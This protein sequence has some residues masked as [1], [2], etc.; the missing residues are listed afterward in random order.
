MQ[1]PLVVCITVL[2]GIVE[3]IA[4][5]EAAVGESL[6]RYMSLKHIQ[7]VSRHTMPARY[8]DLRQRAPVPQD[9]PGSESDSEDKVEDDVETSS[10]DSN[11]PFDEKQFNTSA[12]IECPSALESMQSVVNPSGLAACYNVPF[13]DSS[14]GTFVVDL[15][16]F[17]VSAPVDQFA[18]IPWSEYMM[19]MMIP[20]ATLSDPQQ[21]GGDDNK[22]NNTS[23]TGAPTML[24]GFQNVGQLNFQLQIDKLS[25]YVLLATGEKKTWIELTHTI[26]TISARS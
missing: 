5:K 23:G 26:G 20:Q 25:L 22:S 11:S 17:R 19:E 8:V 7:K 13:F 21:M 18:G 14:T 2:L 12:G 15:R 6:L 3:A 1:L 24:R 10:T 9:E 16:L 4:A